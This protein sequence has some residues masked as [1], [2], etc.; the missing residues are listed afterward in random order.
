MD[1][2]I[3]LGG[4]GA[5]G[6]VAA[7]TLASADTFSQIVIADIDQAAAREV[8]AEIGSAGV[9]ARQVD[10]ADPG[11]LAAALEGVDLVVNC[12]GPFFRFAVPV[13]E[14]CVAARVD[15]VDVCD[16][17][18]ATLDLLGMD[19]AV[20]DAGIL[21]LVGMGNSPGITNLLARLAADNLLDECEA[22]DVYHCHGGEAF[23]GP[24]VVAHRFRGMTSEIPMYLDGALQHVGFFDPDGVALR[25]E[26]D[27]HL[28][29]EGIPV[30]PYPHPEQLTIPDHI[31]LKRVTNKG[32]VL[33][34]E[35]FKLTTELA[36]VGLT[37]QTPLD[38]GGARISP[39]DFA[40]RFLLDRRDR[41]LAET[42]FGSQR[43]CT[44]VEVAGLRR[45]EPTRYVFQMAS[46]G[47]ALGEG[48]GIPA[49]VGAL[50][51]AEGAVTAKGALP[52]EACVEPL[53]F[54]SRAAA[55]L[56]GM[57]SGDT[58]DG[59]RIERVHA[60]GRVELIDLPF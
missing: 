42:G 9:S 5:V 4:A 32:T 56:E 34:D 17:V 38:V 16:D 37:D 48:T 40:I 45:G 55:V 23:E 51:V 18:D 7:R 11:S 13:L 25:E 41:I 43:G 36:R 35:Y 27:F 21:A 12:T 44:K 2:V 50:L 29:G 33:P 58:F 26:T 28:I 59:F 20:R 53:A 47:Q 39:M 49:A 19:Q 54:L 31:R 3:V 22:V 14:A 8:A 52:P 1:K 15:Y 60:D 30:Y 24:G 10:V 57:G 6:R 46:T